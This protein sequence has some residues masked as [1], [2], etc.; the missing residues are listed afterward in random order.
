[1]NSTKD[2]SSTKW[3]VSLL[4]FTLFPHQNYEHDNEWW[5]KIF[6]YSP[7]NYNFDRK[8]NRHH[9]ESDFQ[10]G[11]MNLDLNPL[12][13]DFNYFAN[14]LTTFT[15]VCDLNLGL[16]ED[17]IPKFISSINNF[18]NLENCPNAQRIAFGSTFFIGTKSRKT[19][20][21]VL[22][23][24]LPKIEIDPENSRD[25]LYQINRRRPSSVIDGLLINRLTKWLVVQYQ[26]GLIPDPN[27]G[28]RPLSF[29]EK[30][31][32]VNVDLDINSQPDY[33]SVITP[34]TQSTLLDEFVMLSKEIAEK[35][36]VP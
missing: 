2:V 7:D 21:K 4:R 19:G 20:Y 35:G 3:N 32:S 33:N 26:T 1:M 29:D 17:V 9:Y 18:L 31:Y 24:Y 25:F 36:D 27:T 16:I 22:S 11:L 10:E 30:E 15:Q 5:M 34:K 14:K 28:Q 13:I 23:Q 6:G 12:R 8:I